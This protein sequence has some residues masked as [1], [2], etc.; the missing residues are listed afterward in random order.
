M[1]GSQW[2]LGILLQKCWEIIQNDVLEAADGF[3]QGLSYPK[4]V[5]STNIILIPKTTNPSTFD[6]FRP[7]NMC[8]FPNKIISKVIA[9]RM[10]G[11]LLN[12]ISP[13]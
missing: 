1:P 12:I 5:S 11:V 7:L 6:D 3:F 2:V 4:V 10:A 13:E 8:T 9:N